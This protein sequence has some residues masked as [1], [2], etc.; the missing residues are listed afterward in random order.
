MKTKLGLAAAMGAWSARHRKAAVFGWLLFVVLS[1]Y[2]G[3]L[4]GST[5]VA[6]SEA[7]PGQVSR[8][9][10]I[11]DDAGLTAPASE[12]V[13]VQ[14]ATTTADAPAFRAASTRCSPG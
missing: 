11:L 2:L 7:M 14:S 6:D 3:G 8:A 9:A 10:R 1:G 5:E 12:T 13:L 4:H